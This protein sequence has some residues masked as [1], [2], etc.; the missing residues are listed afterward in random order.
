MKHEVENLRDGTRDAFDASALRKRWKAER[1]A[2]LAE[3]AATE[4]V[5]TA[6]E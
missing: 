4:E 1:R 3:R 2:Q 6:A 5:M